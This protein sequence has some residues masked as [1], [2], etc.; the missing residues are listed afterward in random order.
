MQRR[1]ESVKR[2]AGYAAAHAS[3]LS[4]FNRKVEAVH[5]NGNTIA[6]ATTRPTA[7]RRSALPVFFQKLSST[8][9][10]RCPSSSFGVPVL[11]TLRFDLPNALDDHARNY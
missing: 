5:T 11:T 7:I 8:A 10:H 1:R 6:C 4:N 3:S 2:T 9:A